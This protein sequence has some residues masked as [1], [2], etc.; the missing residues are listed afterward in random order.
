MTDRATPLCPPPSMLDHSKISQKFTQAFK[1]PQKFTSTI[2]SK[3]FPFTQAFKQHRNKQKFEV[4][5]AALPPSTSAAAGDPVTSVVAA[6]DPASPVVG[7]VGSGRSRARG[8]G[9]DDSWRRWRRE[10]EKESPLLDPSPAPSSSPRHTAEPAGSVAQ[11][12]IIA[13]PAGCVAHHRI[14]PHPVARGPRLPAPL[15]PPPRHKL[16]RSRALPDASPT[17]GS[18]PSPSPAA[19]DSLRR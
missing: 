3:K 10:W 9:G 17:A 18:N 14:Q 11:A 5:V 16:R 1:N 2:Y 12:I 19:Q 13:E 8:G 4:V 6:V 7:T 15:D